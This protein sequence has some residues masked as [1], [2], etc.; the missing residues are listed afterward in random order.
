[1]EAP[2]FGERR[3]GIWDASK[4]KN[5][6][7]IEIQFA[8]RGD[9]TSDA[10]STFTSASD[11]GNVTLY[12]EEIVGSKATLDAIRS[13]IPSDYCIEEYTR[14]DN[15]A[16]SD[17]APTTIKCASL[18]SRAG[19]SGF[20]FRCR[21]AAEDDTDLNC[22]AGDEE[23]ESLK[24]TV[25]GRDVYD[26]DSRSDAMRAYQN[27]LAGRD[28]DAA[29]AEPNFA[30]WSFGNSH[31]QY[32]AAHIPA[33]LKNGAVNELDIDLQCE[34]GSGSTRCDVIACHLRHFKFADGTVKVSNAY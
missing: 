31:K 18:V 33:L 34:A 10:S 7:V 12:W 17:S 21:T 14:S 15:V 29:A 4:L 3:G 19:T 30:H 23:V 5:N 32:N 6:L 1:M 13:E 25:D 22:M 27:I 28:A 20:I 24:V 26:T 11:L 8:S 16:V 9:A 2:N